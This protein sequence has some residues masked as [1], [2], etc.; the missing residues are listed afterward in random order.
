MECGWSILL[1]RMYIFSEALIKTDSYLYEKHMY[2][3][4]WTSLVMTLNNCVNVK[5]TMYN[6]IVKYKISLVYIYIHI[7]L[8]QT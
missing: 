2:I 8:Q 6:I 3:Y 7:F 5:Y 4:D 1:F